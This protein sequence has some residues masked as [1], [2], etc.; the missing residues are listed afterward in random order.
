M[1]IEL[2]TIYPVLAKP[3]TRGQVLLGKALPTWLT[4]VAAMALFALA[5]LALTPHLAYQHF[6]VMAQAFFLKAGS[7]AILTAL[8][9]WL[10]LWLPL[11]VAVLAAA[12]VYFLGTP[13]AGIAVRALGDSA[14]AGL[15]AGLVPDFT[16]LHQFGRFVNGGAALS[17]GAL[18]G[19]LA[20]AALWTALLGA[21][22]VRR[23]Q[24]MAL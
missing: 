24:R 7:L 22:A 14:S 12:F 9:L 3:V 6:S 2:R 1:E 15:L 19:L 16:L 13:A 5:T 20:Y 11:A 8:V 10:S 4:G 23:F 17:P 18:A 21:L